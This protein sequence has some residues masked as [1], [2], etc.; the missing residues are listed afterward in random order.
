MDRND[1][2][3]DLVENSKE[4]GDIDGSESTEKGRV[5]KDGNGV[6][7]FDLRGC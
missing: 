2:I 7:V 6:L 3:R 5:Y 1:K 4:I